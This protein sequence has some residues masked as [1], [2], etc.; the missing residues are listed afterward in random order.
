MLLVQIYQFLLVGMLVSKVLFAAQVLLVVF[1][2][3]VAV[4]LDVLAFIYKY[5][6]LQLLCVFASGILTCCFITYF[7]QF[8][9]AETSLSSPM[10][11]TFI[12]YILES[13][14][15]PEPIWFILYLLRL[16]RAWAFRLL[17]VV[18]LWLKFLYFIES[19]LRDV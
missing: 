9:S 19:L 8:N 14:F 16:A 18:K 6:L 15:G 11:K 2:L 12:Y 13:W 3:P 5:R 7:L 17:N 1:L 4:F 10:K